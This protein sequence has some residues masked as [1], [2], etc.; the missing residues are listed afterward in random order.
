M[1]DHFPVGIYAIPEI[2]M[3]GQTELE[4]TREKIPYETAITRYRE[5]ACGQILGDDSGMLKL[6]FHAESHKLMVAHVIGT[7]ATELVHIGQAV[8]ALGGGINYSLNT[9][10]N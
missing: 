8:I 1:L 3:V 5:I 4:L 6:I 9:V 7:V 2:S 10:F